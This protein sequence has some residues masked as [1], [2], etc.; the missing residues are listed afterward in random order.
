MTYQ[1]YLQARLEQQNEVK[2][3]R[4]V[5]IIDGADERAIAAAKL[6]KK[7]NLV[8]PILLVDE[9]IPNLEIDQYVIDYREKL[10]FINEFVKLRK[11]KETLESAEMQFE[12]NAFYGTMLLRKQKIDAVVGG[13]N[14]PTAEILRAAFKIIGPKPDIKTIS[15]VMVVHKN[16]S[17]YLFSDISVNIS[18]NENQLVDIAKNALDFALQLGFEPKPAFLSFSTKGSAKSAQ[19]EIV[20]KATQIFNAKSPIEAY[21]EIQLDAALDVQV[22]RQKYGENNGK[23]ANILIFPNLDAGNIGYKI[24]QRLGG[25]GA[26]GPIITGINAPINDLSRGAT[27]EDVFNTIL[28]TA[29]Q[30]EKD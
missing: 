4:S 7:K 22:R 20:A 26:I 27:V 10:E 28:I 9:T 3:L 24:A 15:S 23:N 30:V 6:L 16:E 14:Y 1:E 5:L 29:L 8:K 12:S 13:L 21:G 25:F 11:G 19:S 18:P 2:S 17:K